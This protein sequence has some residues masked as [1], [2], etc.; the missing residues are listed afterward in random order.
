MRA[1]LCQGREITESRYKEVLEQGE[2]AR[3]Q[4]DALPVDYHTLLASGATSEAPVGL[5]STGDPIFIWICNFLHMPS[6]IDPASM[7]LTQAA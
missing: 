3:S 1:L 6:A 2:Y 5:D 4:A 7:N